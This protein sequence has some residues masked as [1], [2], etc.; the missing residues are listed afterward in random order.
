MALVI[1]FCIIIII[2]SITGVVEINN[3][4]QTSEEK[5]EREWDMLHKSSELGN[6]YHSALMSLYNEY[7][8]SKLIR[9]R[10]K[11]KKQIKQLETKIEREYNAKF[12]RS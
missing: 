7:R 3:E 10:L 9:E 5:I 8:C 12:P 11:I 6:E 2:V 4:I 1:S